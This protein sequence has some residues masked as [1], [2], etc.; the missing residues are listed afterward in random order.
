MSV[1]ILAKLIEISR[2]LEKRNEELARL[3]GADSIEFCRNE[4]AQLE[5]T[6]LYLSGAAARRNS[7]R[8]QLIKLGAANTPRKCLDEPIEKIIEPEISAK[9]LAKWFIDYAEGRVFGVELEPL[10]AKT[11]AKMAE[12]YGFLEPLEDNDASY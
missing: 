2:S 7:Y 12:E 9:E 5:E 10:D 6:V 4:I 8:D 11:E 1:A 3:V